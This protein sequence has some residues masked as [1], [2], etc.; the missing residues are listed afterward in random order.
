L[1]Y[2][3]AREVDDLIDRGISSEKAFKLSLK[4]WQ[5][6]KEP[7]KAKYKFMAKLME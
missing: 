1:F 5:K 7:E 3:L 2:L 6:A 4:A